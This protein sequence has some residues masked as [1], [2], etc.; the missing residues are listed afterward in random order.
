MIAMADMIPGD[1]LG[2]LR[3][4]SGRDLIG[5]GDERF[6]DEFLLLEF[7]DRVGARRGRGGRCAADVAERHPFADDR[8]ETRFDEEP[9]AHVLRLLLRP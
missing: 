9:A 3:F 6:V 1:P 4:A 2:H 5:F 7:V 8:A